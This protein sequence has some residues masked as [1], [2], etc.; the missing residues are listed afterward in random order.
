VQLILFALGFGIFMFSRRSDL[1]STIG[2]AIIVSP[3][4]IL[5]FIRT[6]ER[7]AIALTFIGFML[8][9]N[10]ALFGLFKMEGG[11]LTLVGNFIR[12]SLLAVL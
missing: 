3:I 12:S 2:C 4:F 8:S 1:F 6:Q 11:F 7:H 9:L 5:R 10:I